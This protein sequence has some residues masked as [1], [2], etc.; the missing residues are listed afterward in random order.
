MG[1]IDDIGDG[2][3]VRLLQVVSWF[4]VVLFSIP[5]VLLSAYQIATLFLPYSF[6]RVTG[7][8]GYRFPDY[9]YT[10][11]GEDLTELAFEHWAYLSCCIGVVSFAGVWIIP[12]TPWSAARLETVS[13]TKKDD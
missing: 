3:F 2:F 10:V 7:N 6:A 9:V 8:S 13:A 11:W 5:A 12:N 1:A 4:L